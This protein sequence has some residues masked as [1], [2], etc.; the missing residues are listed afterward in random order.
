VVPLTST[1]TSL[2]KSNK[3]HRNNLLTNRSV[4]LPALKD[5]RGG[6][7]LQSSGDVSSDCTTFKAEAG[8]NSAIK[9]KFQC[10]ANLSKPGNSGTTASGGS[11]KKTGAASPLNIPSSSV[12]GFTGVLAAMLGML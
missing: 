6:F 4:K 10:A 12:M 9:G 2:S 1:A 11:T 5:C 3:G 8:S 7:N